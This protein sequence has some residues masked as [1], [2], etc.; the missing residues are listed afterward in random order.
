MEEQACD[1]LYQQIESAWKVLNQELLKPSSSA[2]I[3]FVPCKAVLL[4]VLHFACVIDVFY[5]ETMRSCINLLFIT[6]IPI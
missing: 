3:E 2:A 4:R 5:G 1:E 6:P